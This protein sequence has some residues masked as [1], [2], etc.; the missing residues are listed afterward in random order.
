MTVLEYIP[1]IRR[2][3]QDTK[4]TRFTDGTI[5]DTINEALVNIARDTLYFKDV[6]QFK[7]YPYIQDYTLDTKIIKV[8]NAKY[9]NCTVP[10]YSSH[11]KCDLESENTLQYLYISKHATRGISV[12]PI[13]T[14]PTTE[15]NSVDAG[16][17][18]NVQDYEIVPAVDGGGVPLYIEEDDDQIV[19]VQGLVENFGTVYLQ[20]VV[21]PP[22][23][24]YSSVIVDELKELIKYYVVY[25]L[26][27]DSSIGSI[28]SRSAKI[29]KRYK[30]LAKELKALQAVAHA[31]T[32]RQ[33]K[34]RS[35]FT[36]RA[37][38][39]DDF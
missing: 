25:T 10:I 14:K 27:L 33:V 4:S 39:D 11:E 5:L 16:L 12:Y 18:L 24:T 35:P 29:E 20:A 30:E 3:L 32:S 22:E 34:Y 21:Y 15:Y 17:G 38:I 26:L 23:V 8:Y 7:I 28:T 6:I 1:I 2:S 13:L 19:G 31:N 9:N 36:T 37:T